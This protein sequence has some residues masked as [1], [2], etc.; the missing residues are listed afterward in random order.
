MRK[1]GVL[2]TKKRG[3]YLHI[4]VYLICASCGFEVFISSGEL[5][6]NSTVIELRRKYGLD[7]LRILEDEED[8]KKDDKAAKE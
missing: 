1:V 5:D 7:A 6:E 8:A 2:T 3:K 4:D